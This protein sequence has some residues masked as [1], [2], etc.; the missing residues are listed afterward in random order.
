LVYCTPP[1]LSISCY[2][3]YFPTA[4]LPRILVYLP[5]IPVSWSSS[6]GFPFNFS[7]HYTSLVMAVSHYVANPLCSL[8]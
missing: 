1:F 2:L 6:G 3:I 8:T 4:I 7:L 5:Q